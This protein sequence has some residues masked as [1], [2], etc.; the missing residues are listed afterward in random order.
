LPSI[1]GVIGGRAR[2]RAEDE[3]L[4]EPLPGRLDAMNSKAFAVESPMARRIRER[5]AQEA[6]IDREAAE[7][8]RKSEAG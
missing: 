2:L 8:T 1:G 4:P 7:D 3:D 5:R 6:W